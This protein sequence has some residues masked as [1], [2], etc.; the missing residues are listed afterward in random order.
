MRNEQTKKLL[1]IVRAGRLA[2]MVSELVS[3][4]TNVILDRQ[5][6]ASD[7]IVSR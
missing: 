4:Y 6:R 7:T 2:T 3:S 1:G 5:S